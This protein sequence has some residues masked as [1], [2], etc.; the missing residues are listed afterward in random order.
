MAMVYPMVFKIATRE[1]A[2]RIKDHLEK[3]FL[4]TGGLLS[5]LIYSGEQWDAP[6]GWAP[7]QWLAFTAMKQYA[8]DEFAQNIAERWT[9]NV[10]KVF[11]KTRRLTEKYN[12]VDDGLNAK[13][14]EYANQDG[15]GWTN[16]VYLKLKSLKSNG[17]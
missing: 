16:G 10:E 2:G 1:Q 9:K 4:K 3:K 8:F 15:F 11:D 5:T 13:G 14:G 17:V 12:V 6:N 7:L